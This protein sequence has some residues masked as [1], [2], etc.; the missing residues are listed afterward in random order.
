M[1][2]A[3][4]TAAGTAC[5][6]QPDSASRTA[7]SSSPASRAPTTRGVRSVPSAETSVGETIPVGV[8]SMPPTAKL[9]SSSTSATSAAAA[10]GSGSS[11]ASVGAASA[12]VSSSG[13][14][15]PTRPASSSTPTRSTSPQA[16]TVGGL[17]HDER[18]RAQLGQH[19]PA[20]LGLRRPAGLVGQLEGAQRVG[21]HSVSSTV[22]TPSRSASCS[23]VKAK[24]MAGLLS[25]GAA[26]AGARPP[27]CA[28]SRWCRR[29][30]ARPARRDSRRASRRARRPPAARPRG[31]AGRARRCGWRHRS[32]TRRSCCSWPRGRPRG[33]GR[34][35]DAVQ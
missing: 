24:S 6:C 22:R 20:V 10:A 8:T 32:R 34:R 18:G 33:R 13:S 27:R 26:R 14:G 31:R 28:G 11:A 1:G 23:S 7:S 35:A 9:T 12:A 17:G 25:P 30:S 21:V 19:G 5:S 3:V 4:H 16:E 15:R 29:R 2:Y